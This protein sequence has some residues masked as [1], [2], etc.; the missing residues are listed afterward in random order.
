MGN[1]PGM[2]VGDAEH[3]VQGDMLNVGDKAPDFTLIGTDMTGKT[4][5]DFAGKV[6][7]LSVVPSLET[8]VC[9]NQAKR[10]EMEA[11]SLGDAVAVLTISADLP[12]TMKRWGDEMGVER[13]AL[14]S[15]HR[16]MKFSDDYG[17]HV[18]DWRVNQRVVFVLDK[19]NVVQLAQYMPAMGDEVD[20]DAAVAK[21]KELV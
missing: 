18:I 9:S 17:T 2:K 14:L 8:S 19:D 7:I 3:T 16:D 13:Q 10:F 5:A 21:A 15:T 11:E 6:K 1:R 4:L 12:F 20:F